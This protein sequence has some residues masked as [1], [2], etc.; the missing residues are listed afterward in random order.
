M[1]DLIATLDK[2]KEINN[3]QALQVTMYPLARGTGGKADFQTQSSRIMQIRFNAGQDYFS[4]KQ[5]QATFAPLGQNICPI[6][7]IADLRL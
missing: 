5:F 1:R 7:R 3:P 2:V 4:R 6:D